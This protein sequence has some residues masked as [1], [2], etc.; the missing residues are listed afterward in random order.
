MTSPT[1][2]PAN[3]Q[4]SYLPPEFDLPLDP[5]QANDFI[6][7]R[8]RLTAS[9]LNI[10]ENGQF[11]KIELLNGQQWFNVSGPTDTKR[12]RYAYRYVMDLVDKNGG[13]ITAGTH[14]YTHGLTGITVPV[15]IYGTATT[16]TPIYLP[17]PFTSVAGN[18]IEISIDN[19]NININNQ[20]GSNL[21]QCYVVFEYLK[22]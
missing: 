2:Q 1:Y 17:L 11:E 7:K 12:T 18:D 9:I 16:A 20:F 13:P 19:T 8:E 6:S 3:S 22:Q 14:S 4:S 5:K 15:H 21:T 10:K